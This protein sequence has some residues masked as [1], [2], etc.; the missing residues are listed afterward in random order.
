LASIGPQNVREGS[1]LEFVAHATDPDG[2]IPAL[3]ARNIP[4][5]AS[6]VDSSNGRMLFVFNPD[7]TQSGTYEVTF[8]ASD[9]QL[10]DS[11][12]LT[13]TVTAFVESVGELLPMAV[14]NYWVYETSDQYPPIDWTLDS[15]HVQSSYQSEGLTHW[16]LYGNGLWYL[17]NDILVRTTVLLTLGTQLRHTCPR[18]RRYCP[19]GHL[20]TNLC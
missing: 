4:T 6:A 7:S 1:K 14:G 18:S 10:A 3:S 20:Q 5:N 8:I 15:V 16:V 11:Q 12:L 17:G 9:G 13:I 2:T 19:G